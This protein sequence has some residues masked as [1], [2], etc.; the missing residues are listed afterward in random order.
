MMTVKTR[1]ELGIGVVA[2]EDKVASKMTM[3]YSPALRTLPWV[4]AMKTTTAGK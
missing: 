1:E 4:S 3:T 2:I